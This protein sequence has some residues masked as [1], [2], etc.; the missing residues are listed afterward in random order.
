MAQWD[1]LTKPEKPYTWGFAARVVIKGLLLFA[2]VNVI[3]ALINQMPVLGRVSVY[4][5]VTPGRKRLPYAENADQSYNLNVY[6]P[7]VMFASHEISGAR[8][9]PDEYRVLFIGDSSVWGILLD[10]DQTLA[11]YVNAQHLRTADGKN[12]RAFNLGYP[13]QTLTKDLVILQYAM[14]YQ[15]DLIVWPV[16]LEAMAR[17]TQQAGSLIVRDNPQLVRSMIADYGLTSIDPNDKDF[18]STSLVRRTLVGQ[19]RQ[20]A[21]W[22]RLQLYGP[23][24]GITNVDERYPKF[25]EPRRENMPGD[26]TWMGIGPKTLTA[27]DLAFDAVEAGM[28]IAG[29]TPM[30]IVNE[31]IF[32]SRGINANLHYN[33]FYPRWAY[34]NYRDVMAQQAK[35]KGWLYL[36]EWNLVPAEEFT[37]SAVHMMPK[38]T[39][40]FAEVVGQ[41]ILQAA[42]GKPIETK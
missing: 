2:L 28:K 5:V 42:N 20:I 41:G 3:W 34:D 9:A 33:F 18:Q 36:D 16:T 39:Q 30:L 1:W 13:D 23:T 38:G 29:R 21:D 15:P 6:N 24:W 19:R 27:D 8:K 10:A 40:I 35:T 12:V 7:D 32:I 31:P 11:A 37:D 25:F 22:L 4:N 17:G 14:R 26:L